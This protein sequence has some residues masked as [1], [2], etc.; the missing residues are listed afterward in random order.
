MSIGAQLF[1]FSKGH[2]CIQDGKEHGKMAN[3]MSMSCFHKSFEG[4]GVP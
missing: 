1:E 3:S 4:K 2:S